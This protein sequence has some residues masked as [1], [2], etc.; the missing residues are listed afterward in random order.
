[1][2]NNSIVQDYNKQS[3]T[4]EIELLPE[5]T[6]AISTLQSG[7]QPG[8]L[9][10]RDLA[11]EVGMINENLH[12]IMDVD[13]LLQIALVKPPIYIDF[14]ATYVRIYPT[15]KSL[16]WNRQRATERVNIADRIFSNKSLPNS[17]QKIRKETFVTAH[18]F[19]WLC[20]AKA[21]IYRCFL[22]H[23][24]LDIL[25]SSGKGWKKRLRILYHLPQYG[26]IH[27]DTA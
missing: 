12:Y 13:I 6:E 14:L 7:Y 24:F 8:C 4:K 17:I 1:M 18:Q 15:V 23:L 10:D 3:Y 11:V 25:Y 9:M 22:W 21:K 16:E 2:D 27:G 5:I 26:K 20:Y 19:A